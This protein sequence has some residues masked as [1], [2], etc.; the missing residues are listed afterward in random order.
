[1]AG[2][3]VVSLRSVF[4]AP[5]AAAPAHVPELVKSFISWRQV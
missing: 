3:W 5:R 4:P 1:M 2:G